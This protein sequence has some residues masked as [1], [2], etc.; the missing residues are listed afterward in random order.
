MGFENVEGGAPPVRHLFTPLVQ[1]RCDLKVLE[2]SSWARQLSDGTP[3]Q[4]AAGAGLWPGVMGCPSKLS[5]GR[6]RPTTQPAAF[7]QAT[8]GHRLGVF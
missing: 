2:S 5:D 1:Q 7:L 8:L 3:V 6:S 4:H